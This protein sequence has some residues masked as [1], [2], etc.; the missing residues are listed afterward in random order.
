MRAEGSPFEINQCLNLINL[1][2][3]TGIII[4]SIRSGAAAA[5][6]DGAQRGLTTTEGTFGLDSGADWGPKNSSRS[7]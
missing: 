3:D 1:F 6:M 2:V 4:N 5:A 7:K